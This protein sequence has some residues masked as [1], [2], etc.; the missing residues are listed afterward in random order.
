MSD[1]RIALRD[2]QFYPILFMALISII[3]I[4]ILAV[5]Y[6]F[7]EAKIAGN[8]S[9]EYKQKLITLFAEPL[10]I[11]AGVDVIDLVSPDAI[12]N[13]FNTY[14]EELSLNLPDRRAY[15]FNIN[16]KTVGF[17]F[18]ISGNGLWGTMRALIAVTPDMQTIIAIEI[19][20]QMETP[21]L[22]ARIEELAFRKQFINRPLILN[23]SIVDYTLIPEDQEP[24]NETQIRQITGA[25]ITSRSV[26]NMISSEIKLI[27]EVFE[28]E[29]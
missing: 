12:E 29:R 7:S 20:K 27:S 25:T 15:R 2:R 4:G 21:G 22:G 18:D 19:Y 5:S 1:N 23:G 17:C 13:S 26:L 6:R 9:R 24:M 3:F 11:E 14:V 10:M 28:V 16:D 8:E